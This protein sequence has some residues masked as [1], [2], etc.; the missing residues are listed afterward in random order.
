MQI[1]LA[2]NKS[3]ENKILKNKYINN[4]ISIL[5]SIKYY[6]I[7]YDKKSVNHTRK[8]FQLY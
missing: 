2:S 3:H 6:P 8:T 4:F 7:I 1:N 5:C